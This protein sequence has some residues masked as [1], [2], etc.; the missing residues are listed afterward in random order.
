MKKLIDEAKK[1]HKGYAVISFI[2]TGVMVVSGIEGCIR[3]EDMT[4]D[5]VVGIVACFVLGALW[6]VNG[7]FNMR[8]AK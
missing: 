7:I 8:G 4:S 5:N 1:T 6:L 2:M 3:V